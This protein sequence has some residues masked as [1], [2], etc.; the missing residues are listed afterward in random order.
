MLN[1]DVHAKQHFLMPKHFKNG[2]IS[3]IEFGI[4]YATLAT[5]LCTATTAT[6]LL[7]NFNHTTT[8][9]RPINYQWRP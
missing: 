3:A 6:L 1:Y 2:R 5:P 7:S 4:T 9:T 8:I